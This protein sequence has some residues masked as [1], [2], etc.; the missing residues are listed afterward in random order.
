MTLPEQDA[1]PAQ[2][3]ARTKVDR[4]TMATSLEAR[5]PLLDHRVV[6]FAFRTPAHLK[7]HGSV[8]KR[9]LKHL[10]HRYV[11]ENLMD[12]PKKGFGVPI[13]H[14]LRGPLKEW[15]TTL[16]DRN[17]IEQEGILNPALISRMW[18]EQ[19]SGRRR[20]HYYLWD[21]LMF[22]IWFERQ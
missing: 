12:R 9:L 11:P 1:F 17:R 6:E 10:V 5:V 14:W 13:E 7:Q 19:L 4:A 16:L 8:G 20:W 18:E 3:D 22:E 2:G 21:V 15:A